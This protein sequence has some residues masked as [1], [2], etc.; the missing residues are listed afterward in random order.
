[1]DQFVNALPFLIAIVFP[2]FF[3][4]LW[5]FVLRILSSVCGWTQLAEHFHYPGKFQGKYYHFQSAH[6]KS[7]RFGG[8]LVIAVN[9]EGLYLVPMI[10]FRPFHK[11]LLIPWSEIHAESFKRF[12]FKGYRITFQSAPDIKLQMPGRTF[13]TMLEYLKTQ[14][15]GITVEG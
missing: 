2:F 4:G 3:V 1:M 9:A 7:I 12:M 5:C 15:K 13:E 8:T 6:M 11:P 10:L 14:T